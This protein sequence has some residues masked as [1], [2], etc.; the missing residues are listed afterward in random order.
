MEKR[1]KKETE[2]VKKAGEKCEHRNA[3]CT[4][5]VKWYKGNGS[6]KKSKK[7]AVSIFSF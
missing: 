7:Q 2:A 5:K 4:Q 6:K 1:G 3:R